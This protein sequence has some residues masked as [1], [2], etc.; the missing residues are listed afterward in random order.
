MVK[1]EI[2]GQEMYLDGILKNN[3]DIVKK[4]IRKDWDYLFVVDG[5]E[6]CGKSVFAQQLAHYVSEGDFVINEICFT[7]Q[8]FKEQVLKSPK[9]NA[10]VWDEAFRGLSSRAAM[11]ETNRTIVSLLQEIRQ[12]NLV[13]IVVLPSIWD[14]D[15]YVA[16]HRCKGLF[17]VHTDEVKHR[18]FFKFYKKDKVTWMFAQAHKM[19]YRYPNAPQFKGR[20]TK[21]YPIPREVY[22][23]KKR[24]S[25]G[26]YVYKKKEE[27]GQ[28][29]HEKR[30]DRWRS[31]LKKTLLYAK[32]QTKIPMS[33]I[34]KDIGLKWDTIRKIVPDENP[35]EVTNLENSEKN[36]EE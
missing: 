18:G 21:F 19:R 10:I 22:E 25:L 32:A 26:D 33:Q 12:R 30:L 36:D 27:A 35:L 34:C 14:L 31:D 8:E 28:T 1:V 24:A 3:L 5:E 11:T 7:P 4:A 23:E 15:K 2:K 13:V 9:Y 17:H 29:L 20:F 6:G 16:L